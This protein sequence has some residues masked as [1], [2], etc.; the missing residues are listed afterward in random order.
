LQAANFPH[1]RLHPAL[2][3]IV[4]CLPAIRAHARPLAMG[5]NGQFLKKTRAQGTIVAGQHVLLILKIRCA[6]TRKQIISFLYFFS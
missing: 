2:C 4:V 3:K 6:F 5:R 1:H